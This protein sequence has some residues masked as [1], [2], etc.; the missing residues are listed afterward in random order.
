MGFANH[1]LNHEVSVRLIQGT[2]LF[3]VLTFYCTPQKQEIRVYPAD[4]TTRSWL[5]KKFSYQEHEMF[6]VV[7]TEVWNVHKYPTCIGFCNKI[8]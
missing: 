8:V 4:L 7:D 1:T 6:L 5:S 2:V 3:V